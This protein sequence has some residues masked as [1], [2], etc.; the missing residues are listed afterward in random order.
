MRTLV[1]ETAYRILWR[2]H[3]REILA[4]KPRKSRFSDGT[5]A[6]IYAA[7][8]FETALIE[9]V[10]RDQF[11]RVPERTINGVE[12]LLARIVATISIAPGANLNLVDL[13]EA[14]VVEL[15]APTDALRARNQQAGQALG[16]DLYRNHT[17]VDGL[18]YPS[19]FD[20]RTNYAFFDRAFT[21]LNVT[22]TK[23]LTQHPGLENVL[24]RL[25][26]GI[27]ES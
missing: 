21:K 27:R 4:P 5:F 18:I 6:V 26:I 24:A 1:A 15:G 25:N 16:S 2:R 11:V 9:T 3:Q 8:N 12:Q 19:R 10:V 17:D 20:G 23:E 13:R 14:G 7:S 22:E